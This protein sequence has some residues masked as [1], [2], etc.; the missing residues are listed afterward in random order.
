MKIGFVS[1]D[2]L[3]DW[4]GTT[5]LIDQLAAEMAAR[6]HEIVIIAH[7]GAASSKVPVSRREY[8]HELIT[9]DLSDGPGRKT[10]REKIAASGMDVCAASVGN[11]LIMHMP[12]LLRGSGIPFVFG[13]PHDPRVRTFAG[14]QPYESYGTLNCADAIQTLLPEYIPFYPETL[15]PRVT[16]I[17]VPAPPP[18]DI[19]LR[20]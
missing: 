2:H 1:L 11:N 12:G 9:L 3:R 20:R 19:D 18:A 14:W 8:P 5:R 10:A 4:H 17:G 16:E 15:R 6:R 7:K 13:D